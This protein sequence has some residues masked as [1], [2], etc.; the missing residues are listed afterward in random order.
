[1]T[2]RPIR[3]EADYEA[4]LTR[5]R[6]LITQTSQSAI[7][8]LDVLQALIEKWE[9]SAHHFGSATPSEAIKF[10]MQQLG[11]KPRDLEPYIGAKSRVSEVL[12]GQRQPTVDQIRALHTHLG[13][14]IESLV[15]GIK[16]EP[17][18]GQSTASAAAIEKLRKLGVMMA[19]ETFEAFMSRA[20]SISPE[21]AMLRKTRTERTNAKTDFGAL[22]AWCAAVL[23]K[24]EEIEVHSAAE[25]DE[26][27][28]RD[29]AR[30]SR[31]SDW[32]NE[33]KEYLASIG[34]A[35][36]VLEHLPGTYLDGAAMCR[37]DGA[38][39]IA[40]TLR[41]DRLDNFWFTLLHEFAH[42]VCHL[43]KDM[44]LILDDLEVNSSDR[45]EA[46]ADEF[47][48]NALIPPEIW[49][50]HATADMSSAELDE[51]AELAGVHTAI[52]AGRWRFEQ[53]DYRKFTRLLGRGEVRKYFN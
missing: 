9:R 21:V 30:L 19:R 1:M 26:K 28:A 40:V 10:R 18:G 22:E 51:V 48:R 39:V 17:P 23:I 11:L 53:S 7:D 31:V 12:R 24:A 41:H 14:P 20:A 16:H 38:R 35:F 46:Q 44:P 15:G 42:V 27:S 29:L 49:S 47:A 4:A 37:A 50:K 52:V 13:I 34:I 25:P 33:L 43:G 5:A 45:M 32:P 8:E 2:I 36:V 6:E 3:T